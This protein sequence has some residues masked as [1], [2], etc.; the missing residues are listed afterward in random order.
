LVPSEWDGLSSTDKAMMMAVEN[1]SGMM[2]TY[3]QQ[4]I[5]DKQESEQRKTTGKSRRKR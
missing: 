1:A 2:Q 5:N 4:L 3:D